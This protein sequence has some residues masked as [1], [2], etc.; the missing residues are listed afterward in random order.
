MATSMEI[1]IYVNGEWQM[2]CYNE[3]VA[4]N[5]VFS[6]KKQFGDEAVTMERIVRGRK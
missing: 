5:N 2:T 3:F 6:L 4:F 1:N